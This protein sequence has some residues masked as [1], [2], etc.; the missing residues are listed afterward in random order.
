MPM[1]SSATVAAM[2][3]DGLAPHPAV[4]MRRARGRA[5]LCSARRIAHRYGANAIFA[6]SILRSRAARSAACSGPRAAARRRCCAASP[7]S[8]ASPPA[9]SRSTARRE[10]R[11]R[12]RAARTAPHRH[13]VP[14]SRAVPAPTVARN[15]AFGIARRGR[16]ATRVAAHARRGR[17]RMARRPA[18]ARALGRPAAARRAGPR[19]GARAAPAPA[20]RA[21]LEPRRRACASS[22]PPTCATILKAAGTTAV[23]VTHDQNEAFAIADGSP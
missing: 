12:A 19:A 13:G 15:V 14:G 23:F 7:A 3:I 8:S 18:S 11:R 6:A 17:P 5:R 20:R 4:P 10:P 16:S 2:S 1:A 22:S 9:A 21:V